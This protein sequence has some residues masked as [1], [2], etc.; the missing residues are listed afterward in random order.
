[1]IIYQKP[2]AELVITLLAAAVGM[3]VTGPLAVCARVVFYVAGAIWAF[4][5][6]VDG[7]NWFRRGLGTVF[8]LY[9]LV[10]LIRLY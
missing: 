6:I 1:M 2:N 3:V 9:L 4:R 5:E 8:A 10:S 7:A